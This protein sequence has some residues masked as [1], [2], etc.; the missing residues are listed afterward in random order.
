VAAAR[1]VEE[2]LA[3]SGVH[4]VLAGDL[5]A[6]PDT[7]SVRFWRGLRFLGDTGVCY[8]DAWESTHRGS[9]AI[10]SPRAISW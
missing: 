7:A 5:D 6:T 2:L 9:Q 8:Q 10:R 3:R 1:F 4:V